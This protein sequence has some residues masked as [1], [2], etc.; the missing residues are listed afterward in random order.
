MSAIVRRDG[1]R[2]SEL[3]AQQPSDDMLVIMTGNDTIAVERVRRTPTRLDG[4][5]LLKTQKIRISYARASSGGR[6]VSLDNEF[7]RADAEPSSKPLQTANF[8]FLGD[9]AIAEIKAGD[10]AGAGSADQDGSRRLPLLP[11][12]RSR[13]SSR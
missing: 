10:G 7:R 12:R 11:I 3:S 4:E 1:A 2:V 9:S 8:R 13:C 6:V 5:L